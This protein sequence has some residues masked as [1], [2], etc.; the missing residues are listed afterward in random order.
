MFTETV[1]TADADYEGRK[2]AEPTGELCYLIQKREHHLVCFGI[3]GKLVLAGMRNGSILSLDPRR[4]HIR[5]QSSSLPSVKMPSSVC[6]LRSLREWDE[7]FLAS[8]MDGSIRLYDYRCMERG[9]VQRYEGHVNSHSRMN[10]AVDG[11]EKVVA[12]GGE[13]CCV[14]LWDIRSG[15]L[16][17]GKR[18]IDS[19]APSVCWPESSG[20]GRREDHPW[21]VW[22]GTYDGFFYMDWS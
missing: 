1:W 9:P 12:S 4:K 14:R 11:C 21:G 6:C 7:Y 22:L 17:F 19:V 16:V 13:D 2:L 8:S 3:R 10:L 20:E 5:T 18:V 15:E